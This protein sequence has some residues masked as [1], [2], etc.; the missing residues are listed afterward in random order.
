LQGR[1]SSVWASAIV[2]D[3]AKQRGHS[4]GGC[5][6]PKIVPSRSSQLHHGGSVAIHNSSDHLGEQ[7]ADAV[8]NAEHGALVAFRPQHVYLVTCESHKPLPEIRFW[9]LLNC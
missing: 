1:W 5:P 3:H 9:Q 7:Q 8:A 2:V 6:S 4:R